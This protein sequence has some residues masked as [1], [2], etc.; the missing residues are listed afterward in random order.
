[1]F[2]V[3]RAQTDTSRGNVMLLAKSFVTLAATQPPFGKAAVMSQELLSQFK[4]NADGLNVDLLEKSW[5]LMSKGVSWA[6]VV[7]DLKSPCALCK[8]RK[9]AGGDVDLSEIVK[10]PQKPSD[11]LCALFKWAYF[12]ERD[13][14]A[15]LTLTAATKK[16]IEIYESYGFETGTLH[17]GVQMQIRSGGNFTKVNLPMTMGAPSAEVLSAQYRVVPS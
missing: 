7:D 1:M 10:H 9:S 11:A 4:E 15:N 6:H 3:Y 5:N 14:D 13:G 17:P 2:Y 8:Y 12:Y 16:L